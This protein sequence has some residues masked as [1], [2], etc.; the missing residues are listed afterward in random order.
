MKNLLQIK[1]LQLSGLSSVYKN[2]AETV[3]N[4]R[5]EQLLAIQSI[6]MDL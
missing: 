5:N 3:S 6:T 1:Q 4:I 2:C